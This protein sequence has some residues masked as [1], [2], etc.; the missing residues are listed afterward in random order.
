MITIQNAK[1]ILYQ[2]KHHT[3]IRFNESEKDSINLLLTLGRFYDISKD[4]ILEHCILSVHEF[5]VKQK[6]NWNWD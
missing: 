6:F 5:S 4:E 3:G 1:E 2:V